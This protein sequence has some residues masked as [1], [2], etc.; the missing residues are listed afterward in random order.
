MP[1]PSRTEYHQFTAPGECDPC[2][3]LSSCLVNHCGQLHISRH[4]TDFAAVYNAR[5]QQCTPATA[6]GAIFYLVFAA[7]YGALFLL[8]ALQLARLFAVSKL[9]D[10]KILSIEHVLGKRGELAFFECI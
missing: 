3:L 9:H 1:Q 6:L 5:G 7:I 2:V 4:F 10:N 8:A